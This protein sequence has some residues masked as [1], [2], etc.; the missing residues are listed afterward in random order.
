MVLLQL[1]HRWLRVMRRVKKS[2]Q[3]DACLWLQ[4]RGSTL[5]G[6]YPGIVIDTDVHAKHLF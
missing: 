3:Y 1:R 5:G 4:Q 6:L 2:D